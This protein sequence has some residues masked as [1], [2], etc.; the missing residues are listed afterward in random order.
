MFCLQH[1]IFFSLIVCKTH[2]SSSSTWPAIR[3]NNPRMCCSNPLRVSTRWSVA[4]RTRR[5]HTLRL[6]SSQ[7]S[8]GSC[9]TVLSPTQTTV[10]ESVTT[11]R[12]LGHVRLPSSI[13]PQRTN[14]GRM[15]WPWKLCP[16]CLSLLRSSS[17]SL[18][19]MLHV[20]TVSVGACH[21]HFWPE[22]LT[23]IR[24]F[25]PRF[26]GPPQRQEGIAFCP[27]SYIF[28]SFFWGEIFFRNFQI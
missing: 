21:R 23:G 6:E 2:S 11:S 22:I 9:S 10:A 25:V 13:S 12:Q 16:Q 15:H 19:Q 20:T 24:H 3:S 17:I 8:S 28:F 27:M 18:M 7:S 14:H 26:V 5:C 4:A 1:N